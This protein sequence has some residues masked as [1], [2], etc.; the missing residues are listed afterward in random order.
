[1]TIRIWLKQ[2]ITRFLK[3]DDLRR[4]VADLRSQLNAM[5]NL[6]SEQSEDMKSLRELLDERTTAFGN[7]L[8]DVEQRMVQR[9]EQDAEIKKSR[10][11]DE[12][13]TDAPSGGYVPWTVRKRRA[14]EAA[15]D[16]SKY[17]RT[18]QA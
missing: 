12:Q 7:D 5:G 1:M 17:K 18:P 11:T 15:S 6:V 14:E 3:V 13:E 10:K 8:T 4:E 2:L 9:I 16:P